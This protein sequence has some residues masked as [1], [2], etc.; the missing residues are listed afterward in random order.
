MGGA[1]NLTDAQLNSLIDQSIRTLAGVI[2]PERLPRLTRRV[3]LNRSLVRNGSF[4]VNDGTDADGW[5][6][7]AGGCTL[8]T[9]QGY[10]AGPSA[11]QSSMLLSTASGAFEGEPFPF[12][13]ATTY[14]VSGVGMAAGAGTTTITLRLDIWDHERNYSSGATQDVSVSSLGWTL[15]SAAK[16]PIDASGMWASLRITVKPFGFGPNVNLDNFAVVA[17]GWA[18]LPEDAVS[19]PLAVYVDDY[20]ASLLTPDRSQ[21][22]TAGANQYFKASTKSP[23]Y[24]LEGDIV[25]Y[26]PTTGAGRVEAIYI[27]AP[28]PLTSDQLEPPLP[29]DAH[30]LIIPHVAYWGALSTGDYDEAMRHLAA[31]NAGLQRYGVGVPREA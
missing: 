29:Q 8:D 21:E 12:L 6:R 3:P 27:T 4:E 18:R 31:Y 24:L 30:D 22:L 1:V 2:P 26:R 11:P 5:K 14:T 7:S 17:P 13:S 23:F 9:T 10:P 28:A 20:P 16:V 15:F 19:R 25:R